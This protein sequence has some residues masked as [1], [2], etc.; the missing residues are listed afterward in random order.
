MYP[1]TKSCHCGPASAQSKDEEK[2]R[3]SSSFSTN[4]NHL[5]QPAGAHLEKPDVISVRERGPPRQAAAPELLE[6]SSWRSDANRC[7]LS[8]SAEEL[9]EKMD[10]L[11]REVE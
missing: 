10:V 6:L 8:R 1:R 7:R 4:L 5:E 9:E 11:D 2:P 3:T